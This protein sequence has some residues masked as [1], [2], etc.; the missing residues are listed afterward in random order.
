M[1]IKSGSAA[2]LAIKRSAGVTVEMNLR[3]PLCTDEKVCRQGIHPAFE[4]QG[5]YHQ[6][7]KTEVQVAPQKAL[8][9]CF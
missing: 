5:R 1:W 7:S 6:K 8:Q 3:N 2:M 4:I 9:S